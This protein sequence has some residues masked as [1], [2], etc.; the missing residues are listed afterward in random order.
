MPKPNDTVNQMASKI[1]MR[2]NSH[3]LANPF[4]L[5][6]HLVLN[7]DRA[8]DTPKLRRRPLTRGPVIVRPTSELMRR[9]KRLGFVCMTVLAK[10]A[11]RLNPGRG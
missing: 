3:L 9:A 10:G 4:Q 11:S 1:S 2:S 5:Q 6:L 8:G 7:R